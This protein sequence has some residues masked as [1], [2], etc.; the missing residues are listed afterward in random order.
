MKNCEFIE[1]LLLSHQEQRARRIQ[2][3]PKATVI[4]G[5]NDTGKSSIIKSIYHALGAESA[6]V[7]SRWQG[8]QVS[9]LLRFR[10]GAASYQIFRFGNTYSLFSNTDKIIGTYYSMTNE[11]GPALAELFDFQLVLADKQKKEI[12]PPPAYLF[13]PFYIDQ[14]KG[15]ISGW[16]SFSRLA[17]IPNW[18]KDVV[19]YHTGIRPNEF[20]RILSKVRTLAMDREEPLL[21]LRTLT[22]LRRDLEQR[23]ANAR[24]DIDVNA[25][26]SEIDRLLL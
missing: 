21:K 2:F 17:Q 4:R 1:I 23:L 19:R 13:V 26:K 18:R 7:H 9:S 10:V 22:S 24:F 8:A 6:Q 15:W 16:S 11:R 5:T 14:D 3:H 25:Y 20:Y 12:T